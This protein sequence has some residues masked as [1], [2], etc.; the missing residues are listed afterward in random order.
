[1]S[2][3]QRVV[4]SERIVLGTMLDEPETCAQVFGSVRSSDYQHRP[5]GVL[6]ALLAS[7]VAS[8]DLPTLGAVIERAEAS[9]A[10]ESIGG[11]GYLVGLVEERAPSRQAIGSYVSQMLREQSR[12]RLHESAGALQSLADGCTALRGGKHHDPPA[13][14]EELMRLGVGWLSDAVR[15][16]SDRTEWRSGDA[17]AQHRLDADARSARG[18]KAA[19]IWA[20]GIE[21]LDQHTRGGFRPGN[22][23]VIA[24]RP[25][26]GKTA[27]ALGFALSAARVGA[28]VGIFSLEM[29]AQELDVRAVSWLSGVPLALVEPAC[30]GQDVP[31]MTQAQWD[32]VLDAEMEV[33][34][35]RYR[36][37]DRPGQSIAEIAATCEAWRAADGLDMVVIDY[38]QLMTHPDKGRHDLSVAVTSVA[39]KG[40]AKRLGCPVLLLSQLNRQVEGRADARSEDWVERTGRPRMADLRDSGAIEQDADMI[41]APVKPSRQCIDAGLAKPWEAR[42]LVLKQRGGGEADLLVDWDGPCTRYSDAQI[43]EDDL[44]P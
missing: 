8:G 5:H 6:H 37:S 32:S 35:M 20:T 25:A 3:R 14:P 10:T 27:L 15:S 11:V 42:I 1:M 24:A 36:V 19:K 41:L 40:L 7:V 29:T 22:L 43:A 44:L 16:S 2:L 21:V 9:G 38:L 4:A 34:E 18:E 30:L 31:L 26:M 13:D 33:R 23:V 17:L 39:A 28:K 12:L